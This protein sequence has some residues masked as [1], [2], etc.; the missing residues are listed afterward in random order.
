MIG[1]DYDDLTEMLEELRRMGERMMTKMQ[2]L[3][4]TWPAIEIKGPMEYADTLQKRKRVQ[5]RPDTKGHV[6]HHKSYERR[7]I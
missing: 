7:R 5:S 4:F 1:Y 3:A 2:K 6:K